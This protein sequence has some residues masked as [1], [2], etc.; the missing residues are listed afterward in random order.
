MRTP[1]DQI[2]DALR[3][4]GDALA[5]V[6]TRLDEAGVNLA[7][8]SNEWTV[9]QVLSHLGSGAEITLATVDVALTGTDERGPDFNASVWDRWNAKSPQQMAADHITAN[10]TLVSRLESID[11]D[12]RHT[13]RVDLGFL[14]EPV[15]LEF[16]T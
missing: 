3:S 12:T 15:D 6:V 8:G 9:A 14:P 11:R 16:A 10:E 1:T 2:I 4:Q 13:V 7:S 5:A